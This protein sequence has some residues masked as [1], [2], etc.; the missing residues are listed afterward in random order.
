MRGMQWAV[1]PAAAFRL[2]LVPIVL[3]LNWEVLAPHIAPGLPNPFRPLLF[4]SHHIPTSS[5][6]D[7]RYQKGPLDFVFL[8][9]YIVV[10]SFLRQSITLNICGPIA[11]YFGLKR[12]AKLDR[13][14]EQG[15]ALVYFAFMGAW[16]V[17]IM[18]TLPTWWFQTK[19]IW[20]EYPNWDIQP[21]FKRYYL[22][23]TAYWLQQLLV[24]VLQLE[25]PRKDYYQLI[26][27]HMVTLWLI[28]WSYLINITLIG[29]AI[30][31][32]M[33]IPD[34][35][36]AFSKILNYIKW[37]RAKVVSF[38]IF[39]VVWTYFR[40]WL[41]LKILWSVWTEYHLM[42]AASM[43][44]SPP[45]GVWLVWWMR[46]Q[47]FFWI[48]CLQVLNLIWY[49]DIMRILVRSIMTAETTDER[50]DDEDEGEDHDEKLE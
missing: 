30:F 13:F 47:M 11:R 7:P 39:V 16:G 36:L 46:H 25:K 19:Y 43:Q 41:N 42:P 15:Y 50:S 31:L 17:R 38:A 28:W 24:L 18:S 23:H 6:D 26:A 40:H 12:Q 35:F 33:D 48:G 44:W 27:H 49:K 29:N 21:E 9:Y 34:A 10:F 1:K 22:T 20:M 45:D 3:F 37:E 4:I 8:A 32:S 2:L 5:P 14:G